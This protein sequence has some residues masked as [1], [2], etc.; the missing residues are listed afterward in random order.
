MGR[1]LCAVSRFRYFR[2]VGFIF[3]EKSGYHGVINQ[4]RFRCGR[5]GQDQFRTR[6]A[7]PFRHGRPDAPGMVRKAAAGSGI[8]QGAC[9][10]DAAADDSG[11]AVDV[12][13][14]LPDTCNRVP[15]GLFLAVLFIEVRLDCLGRFPGKPQR[16]DGEGFAEEASLD[17]DGHGRRCVGRF[18]FKIK[19][20]GGFTGVE[21]E[22]SVPVGA[23]PETDALLGDP[24]SGAAMALQGAEGIPVGS[25]HPWLFQGTIALN[26]AHGFQGGNPWVRETGRGFPQVMVA[27]K[28][29]RLEVADEFLHG[30]EFLFF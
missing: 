27:G 10:C 5:K 9:S 11:E 16:L 13:G 6:I 30:Q 12:A 8:V 17:G 3:A 21:G 23:V 29:D 7:F 25:D 18:H 1:L 15:D 28:D 22:G 4:D 26:G 19:Q 2:K 20:I 24:A 14:G